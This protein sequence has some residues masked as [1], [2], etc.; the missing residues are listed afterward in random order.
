MV[1][2]L[3]PQVAQLIAERRDAVARTATCELQQ[4]SPQELPAL[5]HRLAGKLGAFGH[6]AAGE[7]ARRLM[8]DLRDGKDAVEESERVA[9]ILSL[10]RAG[11]GTHP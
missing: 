10:L 2:D 6:Q 9:E 8:L 1:D 7:A 4:V 5:V 3:A 11:V